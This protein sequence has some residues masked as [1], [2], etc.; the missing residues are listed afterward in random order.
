LTNDLLQ[1]EEYFPF[2]KK[3]AQIPEH[4]YNNQNGHYVRENRATPGEKP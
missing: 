4:A 1:F 3:I 2:I